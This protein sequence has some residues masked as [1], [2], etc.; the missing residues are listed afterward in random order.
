MLYV[1]ASSATAGTKLASVMNSKPDTFAR[2]ADVNV[3]VP[4]P[5]VAVDA[6]IE[7]A[8]VSSPRP[9]VRVDPTRNKAGAV[10]VSLAAEVTPE[11]R[12]LLVALV[13]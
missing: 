9:P 8:S 11:A 5:E 13:D 6:F 1:K 7:S 10:T 4:P 12:A 2:L 3:A